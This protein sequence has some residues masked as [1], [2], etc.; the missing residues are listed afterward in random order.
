MVDI[1]EQLTK[2]L[3]PTPHECDRTCTI[4]NPTLTL[5]TNPATDNKLLWEWDRPA[6]EDKLIRKIYNV[7]I[8]EESRQIH[9][10]TADCQIPRIMNNEHCLVCPISGLQWNGETEHTRSW[11][12]AAKCLPTLTTIKQDPNQYC[13]DQFGDILEGNLNLTVQSCKRTMSKI[14]HL[15][16]FSQIRQ[17]SEYSKYLEGVC[18]ANKQIN[19]YNKHCQH[20]GIPKNISTMSTIYTNAV[21]VEPILFRTMH[22]MNCTQLCTKYTQ[23]VVAYWHC[24]LPNTAFE[25]F[26]PAC[27]YLMRSGVHIDNIRVLSRCNEL[28]CI[29]PEANTLDL[30]SINKP[31]F[32]QTKNQILRVLRTNNAEEMLHKIETYKE[33]T[34]HLF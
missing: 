1:L 9:I 28:E 20:H 10:C 23:Q 4:T 15:M 26:L 27:L 31:T 17:Q 16:I 8:C 13:R 18:R 11:K 34:L 25:T 30:Y 29:L 2:Q 5:V 33:K 12:N 3:R 24:L 14:L 19:K 22:Q 32:T 21:F 7:Y 6:K